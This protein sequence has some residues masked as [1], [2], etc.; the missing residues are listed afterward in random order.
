MQVKRNDLDPHHHHHHNQPP[1]GTGMMPGQRVPWRGHGFS[2]CA[3]NVTLHFEHEKREFRG[4][5]AADEDN[6]TIDL[7]AWFP[8]S[9]F[10]ESAWYWVSAVQLQVHNSIPR[11]PCRTTQAGR[12]KRPAREIPRVQ[13]SPK[14][15]KLGVGYL[16]SS[17]ASLAFGLFSNYYYYF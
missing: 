2:S 7:Q 13:F 9:C 1:T 3:S 4:E 6:Q 12:V 5:N 15:C 16:Y 10:C 14:G 8:K 11:Y 17:N